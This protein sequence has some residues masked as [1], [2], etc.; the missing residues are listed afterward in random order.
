MLVYA[1]VI[2]YSPK[3]NLMKEGVL[4]KCTGVMGPP[5]IVFPLQCNPNWVHMASRSISVGSATP[6]AVLKKVQAFKH[7]TCWERVIDAEVGFAA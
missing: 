1:Y 7:K 2:L 5:R 3:Y 4:E 6:E